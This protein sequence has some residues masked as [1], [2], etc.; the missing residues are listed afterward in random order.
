LGPWQAPLTY[1]DQDHGESLGDET[2]PLP[3][4]AGNENEP[5]DTW[6]PKPSGHEP[7][8]LFRRP[9][10]Q[11]LKSVLGYLKQD[12]G[13]RDARH[14]RDTKVANVDP[15]FHFSNDIGRPV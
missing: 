13:V 2:R 5:V 9:V 4:V 11:E 10:G 15:R 3:Q 1:V 6:S 8:C 14:Q 7:P 12:I